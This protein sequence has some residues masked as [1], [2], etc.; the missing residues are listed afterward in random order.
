MSGGVVVAADLKYTFV[1]WSDFTFVPGELPDAQFRI[2][3]DSDVS[4][5]SSFTTELYLTQDNT[6]DQNDYII[7][8]ITLDGLLAGE[9]TDII[10]AQN[11]IPIDIPPGEYYL[12]L[13]VDTE[14][15]IEESDESNNLFLQND[16]TGFWGPIIITASPE[17]RTV[18]LPLPFNSNGRE[19]LLTQPPNTDF[20][21]QGF[22]SE[23][24]DFDLAVGDLTLAVE[25]SRIVHYRDDLPTL[26]LSA[27]DTSGTGNYATLVVNEGQSDQY[28]ITYMHLAQGSV[29]E[30]IAQRDGGLDAVLGVG[31]VVGRVGASGLSSSSGG[32]GSHLHVQIGG[33]LNF[34]SSATYAI[35]DGSVSDV[36]VSYPDPVGSATYEGEQV[37]TYVGTTPVVFT[38]ANGEF[39]AGPEEREI[40]LTPASEETPE[41]IAGTVGEHNGDTIFGFSFEDTLIFNGVEFDQESLT[42]TSGSAILDIDVDLD[43][44]VESTVTLAGNFDGIGFI[45]SNANGNTHINAVPLPDLNP[46]TGT[47]RS[48]YLVGTDGADAIRSLAGR[49]DIMRGGAEADQFIF[50][51]E[52]KNGAREFDVIGDYEVGV[53]EIVLEDGASVAS[54]WSFFGRVIVVLEGDH[55]VIFVRGAGV[56]DDNLTISTDDVFAIA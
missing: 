29:S 9:E 13:L 4:V 24:Y 12:F 54:I 36:F 23:G 5:E 35:N 40:V 21:H 53:D 10:F 50:G 15:E 48:D 20:T 44:V 33:A 27:G 17:P 52:T 43:G 37:P 28:Y 56:T 3:N 22:F 32:D 46:I 42:V 7:T 11:T 25:E 34:G 18:Y 26:G 1:G 30:F 19:I 31:E 39:Q 38:S 55:D 16:G 45:V 6:I 47:E 2:K 41:I 51:S 8:S 14:N 49:F